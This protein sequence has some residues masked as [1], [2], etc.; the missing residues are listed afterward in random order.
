MKITCDPAKNAANIAKH[1]LSFEEAYGF[2]FIGCRTVIDRRKAYG[3]TRL[4]STGFYNGRIHVICYVE[5]YN[6]IR[7][8]SFRKANARERKKYEK[9]KR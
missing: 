9:E 7:A 5:T 8:I 2:D 6:G 1:G 4:V 3:E